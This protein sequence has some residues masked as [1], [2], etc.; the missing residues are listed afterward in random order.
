MAPGRS[1]TQVLGVLPAGS[2]PPWG[3][4]GTK[5][6]PV[7]AVLVLK[8]PVHWYRDVQLVLDLIMGGTSVSGQE[9]T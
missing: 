4:M 8:D 6:N 3:D 5:S 7:A 9:I 2:E 1:V